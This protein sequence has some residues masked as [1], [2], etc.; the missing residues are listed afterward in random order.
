[1]FKVGMKFSVKSTPINE[2]NGLIAKKS[3]WIRYIDTKAM[4]LYF[5][6][7]STSD[8]KVPRSSF[9]GNFELQKRAPI[10]EGIATNKHATKAYKT[11]I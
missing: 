1:M 2:L 3:G 5:E 11:K 6:Q 7:I 4:T 10:N 9:G 8:L